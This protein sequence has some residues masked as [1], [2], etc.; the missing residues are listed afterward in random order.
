M[1]LQ[2][3]L[4]QRNVI[5]GNG[6]VNLQNLCGENGR[7]AKTL[8][9]IDEFEAY[10]EDLIPRLKHDLM[11]IFDE[12]SVYRSVINAMCEKIKGQFSAYAMEQ[13]TLCGG[14]HLDWFFSYP[15]AEMLGIKHYFLFKNLEIYNDFGRRAQSI[16]RTHMIYICGSIHSGKNLHQYWIPALAN[17]NIKIDLIVSVISQYEESN[18]SVLSLHTIPRVPILKSENYSSNVIFK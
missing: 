6:W 5:D 9:L 3:Q 12:D 10:P 13:L 2:E 1:G 7:S 17:K 15:V 8:A 18:P 16:S 11:K 4:I 14:Q